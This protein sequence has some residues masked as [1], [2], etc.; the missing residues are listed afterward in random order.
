MIL[1]WSCTIIKSYLY[2]LVC[3]ELPTHCG[4]KFHFLFSLLQASLH[5]ILTA[6]TNLEMRMEQMS[7]Q[8]LFELSQIHHRVEDVTARVG[9]LEQKITSHSPADRE[10]PEMVVRN[11][12]DQWLPFQQPASDGEA[13]GR[14]KKNNKHMVISLSCR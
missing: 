9:I 14:W 3:V 13:S 6:V 1:R 12:P 11:S 5:T 10:V 2:P 4:I 7:S 8:F